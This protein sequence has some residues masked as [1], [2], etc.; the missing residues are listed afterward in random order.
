MANLNELRAM[1]KENNLRGYVH[2][3]KPHIIDVLIEKGIL[4]EATRIKKQEIDRLLLPETSDSKM[5]C[6]KCR[7]MTETVYAE[8]RQI[9]IDPK[10]DF[11]RKI[12]NN[13]K[14]VEIR[15]METDEVI[16]YPSMYKAAKAFNQQS[17]II[18]ANDGKIWKN[19]YAIKV[20]KDV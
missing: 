7:Q 18:S 8:A 10:Y 2:Y 3:N 13:P 4:P 15:D 5:Y 1:V 14:M 16:V 12:R 19:R 11:V 9:E 17:R 6:V 20:L